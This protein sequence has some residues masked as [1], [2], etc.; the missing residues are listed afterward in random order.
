MDRGGRVEVRVPAGL[1]T[2][3]L[4]KFALTVG[5]AFLVLGGIVFWRGHVR[6]AA[7]FGL[8]GGPL[9]LA[10]LLIPGRLGPVYRGW[11]A[12][13]LAISKVTTPIFMA[14]VFFLV[15]GPTA[16]VLRA[17]GRNPVVRTMS[18]GGYWVTRS[19]GEGRRSD[20]R[21]QF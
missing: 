15:I 21:R 13:S 11:M 8:L 7:V 10:G 14:L 2:R 17:F 5:A 20:L 19:D 4:R 3:E 18:D 1:T 12:F 16:A 9:I 6:A